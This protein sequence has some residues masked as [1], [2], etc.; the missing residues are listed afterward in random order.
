[1]ADIANNV[2]KFGEKLYKEI[3]KIDKRQKSCLLNCWDVIIVRNYKLIGYIK[4]LVPLIPIRP[5]PN[6]VA[7]PL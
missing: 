5:K 4:I 6:S 1:M 3:A 2:F 7:V